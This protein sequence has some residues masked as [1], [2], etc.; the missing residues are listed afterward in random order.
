MAEHASL[1]ASPQPPIFLGMGFGVEEWGNTV[2]I[3]YPQSLVI[4]LTS[5]LN[6]IEKPNNLTFKDLRSFDEETFPENHFSHIYFN[7]HTAT[8][9]INE[10]QA[11]IGKLV[12]VLK[13]GGICDFNLINLKESGGGTIMLFV[14]EAIKICWERNQ[15][16]CDGELVVDLLKNQG[17]KM[18]KTNASVVN[19][20][21]L[22]PSHADVII[23]NWIEFALGFPN[24][25]RELEERFQDQP[26]IDICDELR[27]SMREYNFNSYSFSAAFIKEKGSCFLIE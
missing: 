20:G 11:L 22:P 25:I 26:D 2:A 3:Q 19:I 4:V 23:D 17:L 18:V 12:R 13:P 21:Q 8:Y 10:W 7:S 27:T 5:S 1:T 9:D 24:V 14:K 16:P 15:N 6:P